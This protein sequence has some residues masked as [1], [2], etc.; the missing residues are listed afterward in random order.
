MLHATEVGDKLQINGPLDSYEN[1]NFTCSRCHVAKFLD[2]NNRDLTK[3]RLRRQRERQKRNKVNDQ[4][5]DSARDPG[6][7]YFS[8]QSRNNY[9]VK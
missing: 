2:L 1:S 6:F 9:D 5:N 3:L 7:L 4:N 8:L